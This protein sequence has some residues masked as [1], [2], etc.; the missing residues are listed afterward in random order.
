M[1]T[2]P[3]R[4]LALG[5]A[6]MLASQPLWAQETQELA[7]VLVQERRTALPSPA[8]PLHT[9]TALPVSVAA[10]QTFT[11][12]DIEALRPRDIF[13]LMETSLGMNITR[14]GS[15][16]NNFSANRGGN[17][18]FLIDGVYLTAT[19]AQ[20]VVGDI[21]VGAVESIQFIRD[22]SVLSILPVMGF[23][24]RVSSPTQGVVVI[25]TQP[26]PG[27]AAQDRAQI[28]ASYATYDSWSTSGSFRHSWMDGRL[29]LGGGYQHAA[30]QGKPDWNM[31]YASDTY[32]LHGGWKD[33]DFMA[34][35]SVFVNQGEREIQRYIGVLPN[36]S[37]AVGQLNSAT[38]KYDPRDTQVFT[39][40]LARYWNGQHTTAL[41]YGRSKA[42]GTAWYYATNVN[43]DTVAG[44]YFKDESTDLN[45]SHSIVGEQNSFKVG[46][47]RIGYVQL[48]ETLAS[49]KPAPREEEIYG[50]YFTDEYRLTPAWAIDASARMDKKHISKGGDKYG[51]D[52]STLKLSDDTWTD[53]AWLLSLGTAWQINPTWR[54]SG[55]Y[56]YSRTPTPDSITTSANQE[57]PDERLSRWELG[58]D[59]KLHPALQASFTPFYYVIKDAKVVDSSAPKIKVFNADT[60]SY[61]ALSVYT[62]AAEVI[63]KGFELNLKGR[64]AD[65][66]LGYEVGWSHFK[67]DS[68]TADSGAVET[69]KNRYT[70][71]L[72]WR[73]G[74][75]SSTLSALRVDEY[76]HYFQGA[77][78][79]TGDFTTVNLNI[80]RRFEHGIKVSLYGQNLTDKRYYTRHKTGNGQTVYNLSDGALADVGATYGIE[81]GMDF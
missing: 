18:S 3:P 26:A 59:A 22:G 4:P 27:K 16:I 1:M 14:Q 40:N 55:R 76:C 38:W 67:D 73:Y 49:A 39:L 79:P 33:P 19:Q 74:P 54:L 68:V 53:K 20:R 66:M 77:C 46:A 64:F 31:A 44:R 72:D 47:Q 48:T 75:W 50:L 17:V 41:T 5:T 15:R 35:A 71:R 10:E 7:P 24:S 34:M 25:N 43:P 13:D 32:M 12:A 70:A 45:L 6:L 65:D 51:A 60:G 8:A 78:L 36:S 30:S 81:I 37:V 21:P 2:H 42:D 9:R 69:P 56:A 58:L 23:G 11:R 63:R 52:G 62:S 29:Q 57:L 61:E 80:S 28:K